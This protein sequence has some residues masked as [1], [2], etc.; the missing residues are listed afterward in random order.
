MTHHS[1]MPIKESSDELNPAV[2]T[3]EAVAPPRSAHSAK[4][5]L[6]LGL[7]TCGVGYLPLAPGTWG[8]LVGIALYMVVRGVL[9]TA[10]WDVTVEFKL[11]LFHLFYAIIAFE[12]IFAAGLALVGV[13]SASHTEKLSGKKD[14]SKVVIDEVAG[15]FI[16]LLP[17]PFIIDAAWWSIILAFILFR[18]F[19]IV[20]PYPARKLESLESGLG[21]MADDIVAGVYAA[22]GV[23][24]AV[25]ISWLL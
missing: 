22:M 23:A 15:Q 25:A 6:A 17:V 10:L 11:N 4:D 1:F 2:V 13:W 19:D 21:I 14:P 24:L 9:M 16:A 7:A 12:M 18:F 20:K 3:T 5:Y 8:S